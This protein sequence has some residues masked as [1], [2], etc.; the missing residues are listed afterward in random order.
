MAMVHVPKTWCAGSIPVGS[1]K[2]IKKIWKYKKFVYICTS[3]V[4]I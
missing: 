4:F 3:I 1:A 2:K